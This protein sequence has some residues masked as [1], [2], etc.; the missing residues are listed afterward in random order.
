MDWWGLLTVLLAL[1]LVRLW[2]G[3]VATPS[4][5]I[6][7]YCFQHINSQS[8][9]NLDCC[10]FI[11]C[12][13]VI[14][15]SLPLSQTLRTQYLEVLVIFNFFAVLWP[16]TSFFL[17]AFVV[18]LSMYLLSVPLPYLPEGSVLS[19]YFLLGSAVL[20]IGL[21][22]YNIPRAQK[23]DKKLWLVRIIATD[24]LL[25]RFWI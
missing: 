21:I 2:W 8:C 14:R 15:F 22:L 19:P 6:Y 4:L 9:E 23:Q 5:H 20:L 18:P 1:I 11:P 12:C 10:D 13:D 16:T 24:V 7:K 3:A 25:S 17:S